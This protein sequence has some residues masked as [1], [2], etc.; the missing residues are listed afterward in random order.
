MMTETDLLELKKIGERHSYR[1]SDND[2]GHDHW[3]NGEK[4]SKD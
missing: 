1:D 2:K 4:K 3:V